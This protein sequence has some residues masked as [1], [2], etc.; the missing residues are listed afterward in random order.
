MLAKRLAVNTLTL[1]TRSSPAT[2]RSRALSSHQAPPPGR[3]ARRWLLALCLL[4]GA[5]SLDSRLQAEE[6]TDPVKSDPVTSREPRAYEDA[7]QPPPGF[8]DGDTPLALR[9]V[10][11]KPFLNNL[12]RRADFG[13]YTE[14]EYHSEEDGIQGIPQGFR[15]HRTNLFFFTEITDRLRFGSEIE[16]ETEFEGANN[17][18]AI[19]TNVEMAFID[20]TIYEEFV[21]RGGALLAPLGRINVNHDGPVRELTERPLVST[22]V[23]PTTLTE[24]GI[25][26]NGVIHVWEEDLAVNYEA[27]AVN[28]FN[29]LDANGNLAVA[30]TQQEQLL[31]SGRTSLGGDNNGGVA[32]TG[33]LGINAVEHVEVGGSWHAGTYDERSDNVLSILA[34]DGAVSYACCGV[35]FGL[36]GEVA[37][38]DF[39][40]D[41]FAR[42]AGVPGRFWG[43]YVQVSAGHM[44]D[45]LST[46]L[47]HVFGAEGAKFTL[48]FRYDWIDL[49]GDRGEILEPGINFR[50]SADTVFKFSY[51]HSG[52]SFGLRNVPG[53]Q[54]FDDDM[55]VFSLSSY[56]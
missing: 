40:R 20:W 45:V 25:G 37:V 55:F 3:P 39:Q 44:P 24:P 16:F 8:T 50:P 51:R 35:D 34:A 52:Q 46:F 43:Y 1:A 53:R 21:I 29:L 36:E 11:D 23:I 27:Y 17:S 47:P 10:Y 15:M 33:R 28:G 41:T 6:K 26:A 4:V 2:R 30:T 14:L 22:Y 54:T 19:E 49:D 9:D 56:F 18:R 13:G 42:T 31:R 32:S 7:T 5:A 12:W 38:A 48:A